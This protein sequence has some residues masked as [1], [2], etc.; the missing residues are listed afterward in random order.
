MISRGAQ[1]N[2]TAPWYPGVPWVTAGRQREISSRQ[3]TRPSSPRQAR[4][5]ERTP[6]QVRLRHRR[7]RLVARQG[8][9]RRL[10]RRHAQ[11][12]RPQGRRPEVRPVHQRRPGHDEPVPARRGVR[13]RGRRRDRPRHRALR[14]LPRPEPERDREPHRGRRLVLG[15]PQGAPRRVPRLDGAGDPA[16]HERDQGAHAPRRRGLGHGRRHLRDRRHGRRHRVAAVP[17]GDPPDPPRG[18]PR[19]RALPPRHARALRRLRRRAEDEA[20]AALGQR[21]APHRYPPGHRRL[22]LA[23]PALRRHPRQDRALRRRRRRTP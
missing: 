5:R 8:H 20:D 21:A 19:E 14:A 23:R 7:R 16:H 22:P 12:A 4:R 1:T 10:A 2:G 6:G 13:D 3:P 17:R 18:R 9:H 15:D 11:G